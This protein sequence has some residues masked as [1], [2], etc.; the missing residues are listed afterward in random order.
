MRQTSGSVVCPECGRLVEI[1]ETRCPFCGR[2]QPAMFG[3]SRAL[4]NVFGT[5]DVSNAILW[6]CAILYMLS[7]I[8]DPRAILARGGF[9]DI[10]SPSGE[11]LLQLG[12]TSRRLVNHY[13]LW[14]TPLS[15]TYLH[16]SLI[17]IFFNMM[18]L[19]M[20]GPSLQAML[21]PG[22][23]F[24]LYTISGI[25]GFVVSNMISPHPSVGAS[26]AIFGLLAA[27][28]IAG[29]AHGG[30]W[31]HLASR[32]ALMYAGM[33]FMFGFFS[34]R[35]NN[36]AHLGGFLV[37]GALTWFLLRLANR[38]EGPFVQVAA[39]LAGVATIASVV[40]SFVLVRFS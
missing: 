4:Q 7:L 38:A 28:V 21:G 9:M 6:T 16:G 23:F 31:G 34:P 11:A 35:T 40:A 25:G 13:D 30:E 1:D 26:G 15:A 3:Y 24:L 5:L 36:L 2:W 12:M 8:L 18:W 39:V 32:Q 10:L 29:R 33:I 19:R 27:T 37:G 22:R 20:L 14:W 17:H